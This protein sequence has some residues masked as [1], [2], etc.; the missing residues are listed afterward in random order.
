MHTHKVSRPITIVSARFN[1]KWKCWNYAIKSNAGGRSS[2]WC[3]IRNPRCMCSSMC[4]HIYSKIDVCGK[5][6]YGARY[7]SREYWVSR[8]KTCYDCPVQH[9]SLWI[10]IA[11]VVQLAHSNDSATIHCKCPKVG[12]E[13]TRCLD[14]WWRCFIDS[15]MLL[16]GS[17]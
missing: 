4:V 8:H 12:I 15:D 10:A 9:W 3:L 17:L 14:V 16:C 2:S 7:R 6:I 5:M 1:T 13:H 11:C